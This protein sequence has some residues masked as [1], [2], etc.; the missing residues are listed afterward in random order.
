MRDWLKMVTVLIIVLMVGGMVS[1]SFANPGKEAETGKAYLR[2]LSDAF[3]EAAEKVKPAVVSIISTKK[4]VVTRPGFGPRMDP[5]GDDFFDRFFRREMPRGGPRQ[6]ERL[7]RGMGSGIVV[8]AKNGYVLT[9]NHV[10]ED[11]DE[12][13]IML[14][15]KRQFDAEVKGRDPKTDIAVLKIQDMDGAEL[16]EVVLGDSDDLRVGDWVIAIGNPFELYYTVTAG[17]VSA[18]GRSIGLRQARTGDPGYEDFIQTDAAINPGNSGGPLIDLEGNVIGINDAIISR[19]GGYQGIGFAIPVNLAKA[20]MDQ[21]VTKGKVTRG[22]LGVG[23]QQLDSDLAEQFGLKDVKG[24]LVSQVFEDSPAQKAGLKVGDVILE[25]DGTAV[26][27]INGL[28]NAIA[29]IQPD[30]KVDVVVLRD[31]KRKTIP[32]KI[33][34]QPTDLA[35]ITGQEEESE[36]PHFGILVSGLTDELR[37]QGKLPDDLEGVV[38]TSV[39]KNSIAARGGVSK[40]DVITEINREKVTSVADFNKIMK[41]AEKEGSAL[42]LVQSG[43][44]SRF[45]LLKAK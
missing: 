1:T 23:I 6:E 24:A 8:D 38:V 45:I 11:A 19:S 40:G 2:A 31:E 32:V 9:A 25:V 33:G 22:W 21:L 42:L 43:V 16:P 41:K 15:D 17:I 4:M 35:S 3:A 12:I 34:D 7:Q 29:M 10:V 39:E 5:F 30:T 26:E 37:K 20:V 18:K 27:D 44:G 13:K 28:R 36:E 14:A